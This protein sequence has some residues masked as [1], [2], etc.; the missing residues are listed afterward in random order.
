MEGTFVFM[1]MLGII[2]HNNSI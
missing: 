1:H 2:W